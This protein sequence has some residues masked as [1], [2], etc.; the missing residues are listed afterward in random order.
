[1]NYLYCFLLFISHVSSLNSSLK[2]IAYEH[3]R[4]LSKHFYCPQTYEWYIYTHKHT[5][6]K[7]LFAL[8][9]YTFSA[10]ILFDG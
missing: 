7:Q 1:M 9:A 4:L 5:H 2:L 8:K 10:F 3:K 6:Q